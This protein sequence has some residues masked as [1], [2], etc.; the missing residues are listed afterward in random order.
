MLR[1]RR[2]CSAFGGDGQRVRVAG[3]V[4]KAAMACFVEALG[5]AKLVG[6][7]AGRDG[8][9]GLVGGAVAVGGEAEG[10]CLGE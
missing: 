8:R 9:F 2:E 1:E 5:A 10:E 4:R 6:V 3:A 7:A